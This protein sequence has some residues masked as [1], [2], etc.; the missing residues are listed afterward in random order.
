MI[1]G[2]GG[3]N[4]K[5]MQAMMK[6]M[7]ISQ[8]EISSERVIIEKSDGNKIII[9]NP[10]VMKIKMQGQEN[11]QISGDI[12]EEAGEVSVSEEDIQTIVEKTNVSE[13]IAREKLEETKDLAEAILQLSEN[14][15]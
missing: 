9:S 14:E 15:E 2:M 12:S 8:E 4:P 1:P 11:F 3:L 6:Q 7:G 5:K 13:D 10:S